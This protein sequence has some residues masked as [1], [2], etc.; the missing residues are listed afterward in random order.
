[1][2]LQPRKIG[3]SK[4]QYDRRVGKRPPRTIGRPATTG[5]LRVPPTKARSKPATKPTPVTV[6]GKKPPTQKVRAKVDPDRRQPIKKKPT[7]KQVTKGPDA[8]TI[9]TPRPKRPPRTPTP[10][11]PDRRI[12]PTT[13]TPK[14]PPRTTRPP[15]N[16]QAFIEEIR[17]RQKDKPKRPRVPTPKPAPKGM[18]VVPEGYK[19]IKW[20]D[21][22]FKPPSG[23]ATQAFERFYNPKTKEVVVVPSGGYTPPKGFIRSGSLG[24]PVDRRPIKQPIRPGLTDPKGNPITLRP[25]IK[26]P[27]NNVEKFLAGRRPDELNRKDKIRFQKELYKFNKQRQQRN[28]DQA[29]QQIMER[30]KNDPA[31]LQSEIARL[32]RNVRIGDTVE[33]F[34]A[35]MIGVDALKKLGIPARSIDQLMFDRKMFLTPESPAKLDTILKRR[36]FQANRDYKEQYRRMIRQG[37]SRQ[38]LLRMQRSFRE[39]M[40][41]MREGFAR[42][43]A[44]LQNRNINIPRSP[45]S[46]GSIFSRRMIGPS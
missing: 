4:A 17:R 44:K 34:R 10:K 42:E 38:D 29:R 30:F 3:E 15:K 25:P 8:P 9:R 20:Q 24:G 23:V 32:D 16:I 46:L 28:I 7:P 5:R 26:P 43:K 12:P 6:I 27:T 40:R 14:R 36:L 35:G 11:L 18:K 39:S 19:S 22:G 45:R 31:R 37:A 41:R 21:A 1:M 33:K 13:P 2:A